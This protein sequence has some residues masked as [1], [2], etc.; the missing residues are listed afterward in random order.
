MHPLL[1]VLPSP[2]LE[3]ERAVALIRE[4]MVDP[5]SFPYLVSSSKTPF[6]WIERPLPGSL[7]RAFIRRDQN[8]KLIFQQIVEALVIRGKK[9]EYGNVFPGSLPGVLAA[10]EY[11]GYFL[12]GDEAEV[13]SSPASQLLEVL[14]SEDFITP[15][16]KTVQHAQLCGGSPIPIHE[17]TWLPSKTAIAVPKDRGYLGDIHLFGEASCAIVVHNP[18]RG[19]AIAS[20]FS[21]MLEVARAT[22]R[23]ATVAPG[24][25]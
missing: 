13:A 24:E 21:P 18:T 9:Y 3:R 2:P 15:E 11:V 8:L 5:R 25:P 20:D 4:F 1:R 14:V 22:Q 17:V 12:G 23:D 16:S 19:L 10:L 6:L 7:V